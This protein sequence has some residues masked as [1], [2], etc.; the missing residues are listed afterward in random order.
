METSTRIVVFACAGAG[1]IVSV[2]LFKRDIRNILHYAIPGTVAPPRSILRCSCRFC[3]DKRKGKGKGNGAEQEYK[4]TMEKLTEGEIFATN[5]SQSN[6]PEERVVARVQS[7]DANINIIDVSDQEAL[8]LKNLRDFQCLQEYANLPARKQCS[9]RSFE[10]LKHDLCDEFAG[11][12]I[13]EVGTICGNIP[14]VV[15]ED[16]LTVNLT[17][18]RELATKLSRTFASDSKI[19]CNVSQAI[20]NVI[21]VSLIDQMFAHAAPVALTMASD[22]DNDYVYY[23]V[24]AVRWGKTK[25]V[26]QQSIRMASHIRWWFYIGKRPK[27]HSS[28]STTPLLESNSNEDEF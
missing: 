13:T 2:W 24:A 8:G 12:N 14:S 16:L 9:R 3:T 22:Y 7:P 21:C 10:L 11:Q 19:R 4:E 5:L 23:M 26:R 15:F 20:S 25:W 18:K 6:P 28:S 27:T 17:K 1:A